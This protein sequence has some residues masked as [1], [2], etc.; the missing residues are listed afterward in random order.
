LDSLSKQRI[1][2]GAEVEFVLVNDG[3]PDNCLQQLKEFAKKDVRAVVID[4]K[5]QGVSA[6]R[7]A[8][9]KVA[10]GEYVFFLD[11]DDWLTDDASQILYEVCNNDKP[12]IIVTNAYIIK[13][14]RFDVKKEWNPCFGLDDGFYETMDFA[15][16]I[17]HL[18]ISFKAYKREMLMSH[19]IYYNESLRVGEVYAFFL[20]A[21]T[22]SQSIAFTGKRIMNYLVRDSSVMRT[23]NLE[24]D[25]TIIDTMHYIEE[26]TK[27][28]MPELRKEASYKRSLFSIVNAFGM[29]NYVKKS[30]YTRE[31][32]Q[33]LRIINKDAIYVDLQKFILRN[34]SKLNKMTMYGIAQYYLPIS[35]SYRLIRLVRKIRKFV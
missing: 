33:L 5:N 12:H 11:S 13:E 27:K 10:Q 32:G 16:K 18:P 2:S 4:Q 24:R 21:M 14:G 23:V 35:C 29:Q 19:H 31:I 34:D 15:R 26:I 9:L 25:S 20:N 3:S 30:P 22:F 6:A 1:D 17:S 7:N 28:Q 8:G